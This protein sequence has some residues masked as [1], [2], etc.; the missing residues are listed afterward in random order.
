MERYQPIGGWQLAPDS[1]GGKS[2]ALRR[3][4]PAGSIYF[5]D[6]L[7]H[8]LQPLTD[9]GGQIGYGIIYSGDYDTQ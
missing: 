1:N 4:A 2:K 9:Y 5:F 6:T 3:C 7:V 8:Q